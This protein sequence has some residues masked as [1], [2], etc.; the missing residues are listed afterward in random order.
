MLGFPRSQRKRVERETRT[1]AER[2]RERADRLR[3]ALPEAGEFLDDLREQ[4]EPMVKAAR[5]QAEPMVKAARDRA[6]P[7]VQ[8]ARERAEQARPRKR[9]RSKRPLVIIGL[10]A[11][12]AL[13]AFLIFRKR[14]EEPAYL[15][16]EPE[17]PDMSPAHP[18]PTG[19][20]GDGA[21]SDP[22]DRP[23]EPTGEPAASGF[24]SRSSAAQ[25]PAFGVPRAASDA[26][27]QPAS[28]DAAAW[29]LPP[30]RA[31]AGSD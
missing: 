20:A 27:H 24:A 8:A 2:G 28:R 15:M 21:W 13:V 12:A 6:E 16:S 17:R 1:L 22:G 26:A 5:E 19:G 18:T 23:A 29:D 10:V 11:L 9:R 14:D 25:P 4:A 7:M 3:E 31:P 30:M